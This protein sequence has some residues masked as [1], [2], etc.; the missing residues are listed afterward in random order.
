M[1]GSYPGSA[2]LT[3][4]S[5]FGAPAPAVTVQVVQAP[6]LGGGDPHAHG[7]AAHGGS[8]S[9]N[10]GGYNY[11]APQVYQAVPVQAGHD[12]GSHHGAAGHY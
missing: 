9:G 4:G 8:V 12:H 1:G 7:G 3:G 5:T 6:N 10:G 2:P 11:A